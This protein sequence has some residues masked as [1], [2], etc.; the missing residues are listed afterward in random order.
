MMP[1]KRQRD[2]H[3]PPPSPQKTTPAKPQQ[4][5]QNEI[6]AHE[7]LIDPAFQIQ[8]EQVTGH[9]GQYETHMQNLY[10]TLPRYIYPLHT[11][12]SSSSSSVNARIKQLATAAFSDAFWM[13]LYNLIT[14][15][16]QND[17]YKTQVKIM[18]LIQQV[19]AEVARITKDDASP[20]TLAQIKNM[21]EHMKPQDIEIYNNVLYPKRN[22]TNTKNDNDNAAIDTRYPLAFWTAFAKLM[23]NVLLAAKAVHGIDIEKIR[24]DTVDIVARIEGLIFNNNT[25]RDDIETTAEVIVEALKC[26]VSVM[27]DVG[28]VKANHTIRSIQP[29]LSEQGIEFERKYFAKRIEA[30]THNNPLAKTNEMLASTVHEMAA[31]PAPTTRKVIEKLKNAAPEAYTEVAARAIVDFIAKKKMNDLPEI[32]LLDSKRIHRAQ[33]MYKHVQFAFAAIAMLSVDPLLAKYTKH[34]EHCLLHTQ[35]ATTQHPCSQNE[36]VVN[37]RQTFQKM[38]PSIAP[39]ELKQLENMLQ[40]AADSNHIVTKVINA[41]VYTWWCQFVQHGTQQNQ[42][43]KNTVQKNINNTPQLTQNAMFIKAP[44]IT[45]LLQ[46][47][48]DVIHKVFA[49]NIRVHATIYN[50]CITSALENNN[51]NNS[52]SDNE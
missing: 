50:T 9:G 25:E 45:Q 24:T 46:N 42:S 1:L 5:S 44:A 8:P 40:K 43:T 6:L 19:A 35:V 41:R 16:R 20:Q 28:I 49:L 7:L 51:S 11:P 14:K 21:I 33:A 31:N 17:V 27:Y 13:R 39:D 10:Q 47:E 52:N 23:D 38:H 15:T 2:E 34:L 37:L 12:N 30:T 22:K 36:T 4:P 32:L 3:T 29:I 18:T 48:A 26:L